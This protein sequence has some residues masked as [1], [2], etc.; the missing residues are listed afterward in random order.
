MKR[1]PPSFAPD[2]ADDHTNRLGWAALYIIAG[3]CVV[4]AFFC[5]ACWAF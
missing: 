1:P 3:A 4:L 2:S 5:S